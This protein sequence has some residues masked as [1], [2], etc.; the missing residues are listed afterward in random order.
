MR[1]RWRFVACATPLGLLTAGI[2]GGSVLLWQMNRSLPPLPPPPTIQA[3]HGALPV[4][5]VALQE[6][7]LTPEG[8]SWVGS[9]F[10]LQ[11]APGRV[12]L[13][14]TAHSVDGAPLAGA[15]L[16]LR[17]ADG[18]TLAEAT[19]TNARIGQPRT[20]D[21]LTVDYLL[22]PL[23][24]PPDPAWV[25]Y[26]DPRPLPQVGERVTLYTSTHPPIQATVQQI[27]PHAVWLRMDTWF[28]PGLSSGAPAL[29]QHTG[30]VVGMAI[31]A[32][33]VGTHLLIGLHPIQFLMKHIEEVP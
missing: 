18:R 4:L 1:I 3:P 21:D 28:L 33:F 2:V 26:P 22:A 15:R 6:H 31:A 23:D 20:T 29:S 19:L 7:L 17:A 5:N 12:F 14:T 27:E 32:R 16:A 11:V 30:G 24:A 25:L 8:D 9:G 10:L 13:V